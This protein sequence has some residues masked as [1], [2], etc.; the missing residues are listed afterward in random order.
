[1]EKNTLLKQY[2]AKK[3]EANYYT[4]LFPNDKLRVTPDMFIAAWKMALSHSV[5]IADY[6]EKMIEDLKTTRNRM[7]TLREES[8][9]FYEQYQQQSN[10]QK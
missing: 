6:L 8:E 10:P 2:L 5:P 7:L 4:D 3:T 1:M 9:D